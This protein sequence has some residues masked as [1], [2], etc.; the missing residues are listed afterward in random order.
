MNKKTL[1]EAALD[2]DVAA[3][4]NALIE[5]LFAS[6]LRWDNGDGDDWGEGATLLIPAARGGS[7]EVVELL[8]EAGVDPTLTYRDSQGLRNAAH[9]AYEHHGVDLCLRLLQAG[10]PRDITLAAA[11]GDYARVAELLHNNADLVSDM[12]TGLSPL[13]WAAYGQ[14]ANMIP[15]L[16]QRGAPYRGEL[17]CSASV[18]HTGHARAFLDAGAD[19]NEPLDG[20]SEQPLH[21]AAAMRHTDDNREM[22]TLLIDAGAQVNGRDEGMTP[23]DVA[24][25]HHAA[26]GSAEERAGYEGVIRVLESRGGLSA[27]QID[28]A[29]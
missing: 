10:S 15:Y 23:L 16:M 20:G 13:A 9:E 27:D 2:G 18:G 28:R 7:L 6:A 12:S 5:D 26:A 1:F 8:L 22:V 14:D 17:C 29:S 4:R 21:S 25:A 19:P 11:L 3:I 24:R